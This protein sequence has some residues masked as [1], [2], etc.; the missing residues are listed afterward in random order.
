MTLVATVGASDAD[1][2]ATLA[3]CK[4]YWDSVGFAYSAYGDTEIEE[5][6][7][8]ARVWLDARYLSSYPGRRQYGRTAAEPQALE[9]PR[10]DAVDRDGYSIPTDTVPRE[11]KNAQCEAARR[12]VAGTD[13]SPDVTTARIAKRERVGSLEVEYAGI[14]SV[15]ANR[16]V[17]P[18]VD[19]ILSALLHVGSGSG[20]LQRL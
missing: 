11:V 7:R 8:R 19:D 3:E 4:T 5:A 1:T 6:L 18:V 20:L 17:I 9:W 13:L 16:P 15:S 10:T 12:E 14:P 2:Y